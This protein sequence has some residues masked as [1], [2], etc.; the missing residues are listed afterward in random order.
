MWALAPLLCSL[1]VLSQFVLFSVLRSLRTG[2]K[3]AIPHMQSGC[4]SVYL[5]FRDST[6]RADM[7]WVHWALTCQA[8]SREFRLWSFLL[9]LV[10]DM[11]CPFTRWSNRLSYWWSLLSSP[12]LQK[13]DALCLV[14]T[15][16]GTYWGSILFV[17]FQTPLFSTSPCG[18]L[19]FQH[20]ERELPLI[21]LF[22][23]GF[24]LAPLTVFSCLGSS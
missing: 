15:S 18:T 23:K 24:L 10:M 6:V 16:H 9:G 13:Q 3:D 5:I 1:P 7:H 14:S 2:H 12:I 4:I 11:A 17:P 19:L 8:L 21:P 22:Y 20:A